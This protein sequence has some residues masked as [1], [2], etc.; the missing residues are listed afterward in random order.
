V[1][2]FLYRALH[3]CRLSRASARG[4]LQEDGMKTHRY[5]YGGLAAAAV[6]AAY[7]ANMAFSTAPVP[8]E[9]AAAPSSSGY[10]PTSGFV[11]FPTQYQNQATKADDH[12]ENF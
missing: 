7:V 9:T 8:Q 10:T 1:R 11:Y 4:H 12:V 6:V 2:S 5:M 3:E